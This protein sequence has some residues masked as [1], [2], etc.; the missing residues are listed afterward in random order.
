ITL[1]KRGDVL[2]CVGQGENLVK[3][4]VVSSFMS[5]ASPV[6]EAMFNGRFSEGQDL[7]SSN[8]R[9]TLLPDD[10]P[11]IMTIVCR[12]IHMQTSDMPRQL[13]VDDFAG[14]AILCDKYDCIDAVR[15]W[16][17]LWVLGLL[18]E[19]DM[20][21]YDKLLM[22]TYVLDL[23][24]EFYKVTQSLLKNRTFSLN[25]EVAAH[26]TDFIPLKVFGMIFC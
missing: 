7:S 16:S 13:E 15:P 1:A 9:E 21:G 26:S 24:D 25:L 12:M 18:P 8:P 20:P 5:V 22:I 17:R 4:L 2:L 19:P 11:Y 6:F 3:L 10:D 14:F 23:P